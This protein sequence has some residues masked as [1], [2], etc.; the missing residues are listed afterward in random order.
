MLPGADSSR[1]DNS[2]RALPPPDPDPDDESS[3]LTPG[4]SGEPLPA[5]CASLVSDLVL[6]ADVST[7]PHPDEPC[8][9]NSAL[10]RQPPRPARGLVS[11]L[12]A[13]ELSTPPSELRRRSSSA[14]PCRV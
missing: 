14:F 10:E 2:R 12:S 8:R 1:T 5:S 9:S 4:R 6:D 7:R 11:A 3:L 13:H